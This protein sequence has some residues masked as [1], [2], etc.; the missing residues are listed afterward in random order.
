MENK[1]L[2]LFQVHLL[3]LLFSSKLISKVTNDIS[4]V[5]IFSGE[6]QQE[7][8]DLYKEIQLP[9]HRLIFWTA[10]QSGKN[11]FDSMFNFLRGLS[12]L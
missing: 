6:E 12:R 9:L 1:N 8:L 5:Q 4:K 10:T 3:F 2:D 7:P 11:C